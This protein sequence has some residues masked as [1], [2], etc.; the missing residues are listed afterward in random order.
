MRELAIVTGAGTGLGQAVALA[1]AELPMPVMAVGRREAPLRDTAAR[2]STPI[3]IVAADVAGMAGRRRIRRALR[4]G[5]RVRFLVHAAGLH[6]IERASAITPAGWRRVLA[7]NVDARLFLTLDLLPWLA[8]GARVLFVGSNSA[9]K[10]RLSA[11]AYCVS[12]AGSQ[13]LQRCLSLELA[14][15]GIAV[16]AALPS[17]VDTPMVAAQIAADPALYPD[18]S[19]YRRLRDAGTLIAPGTVA[20][21]YRWLLT[22][23]TAEAFRARAWNIRDAAHHEQWLQGADLYAPGR[24]TP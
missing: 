1:L 12:Q 4:P 15:L 13:M 21:F 6:A 11:T 23:T 9:T 19:D 18:A 20:R 17:P 2:S 8:P 16:G 7:T 24:G 14:P 22:E 10:P 5:D 3:E